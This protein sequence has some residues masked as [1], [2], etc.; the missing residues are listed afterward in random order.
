MAG[1]NPKLRLT[2]FDPLDTV[3][4]SAPRVSDIWTPPPQDF[5]TRFEPPRGGESSG[6]GSAPGQAPREDLP[7]L[8]EVVVTADRYPDPPL[9][10][11]NNPYAFPGYDPYAPPTK[12]APRFSEPQTWEKQW[13]RGRPRI[14]PPPPTLLE[15]A[16]PIASRLLLGVFSLFTPQPM[17]PRRFDEAPRI[18]DFPWELERKPVPRVAPPPVPVWFDEPSP[19][20]VPFYDPIRIP[21]RVVEPVTRPYRERPQ[22][23]PLSDPRILTDPF[24]FPEI[25]FP[26]PFAQP[27]TRT[28]PRPDRA[29][30][31]PFPDSQPR[32]GWP[33][34]RNPT[35]RPDVLRPPTRIPTPVA[36]P[37][38]I[39]TLDPVLT[40]FE[41][42]KFAP[43]VPFGAPVDVKTADPCNCEP[44]EK[45]KKDPK[46]KKQPRVICYSGTYK[47]SRYSTSKTPRKKVP[48]SSAPK[49]APL[50]KGSK[51]GSTLLP[52]LFGS[53]F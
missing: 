47:E 45:K 48:C 49:K 52:V 37:L 2:P 28:V 25:P 20:E 44:C 51:Q 14:P 13:D 43:A 3:I 50:D 39:T 5:V 7:E 12:A 42:P 33:D 15:R 8:P 34:I 41:M 16:L 27:D 40:P 36:P 24:G 30:P 22:P 32:I 6:G 46:K 35:N 4:V 1:W 31:Y 19:L 38:L 10:A 17:G 21:Q 18:G 23:E 26:Q 9:T 53:P 11:L 29:T